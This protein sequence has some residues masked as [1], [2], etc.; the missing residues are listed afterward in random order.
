[1]S[2]LS[3]L[4]VLIV[5]ARLFGRLFA[6]Y[7]QPEVIGE[8]LA[9]V[10]L[11]PAVLDLIRP[12][13]ALAGI[14]ELAVFLVILTAGLEMKI[15]HILGAMRGRGLLL[16]AIGFVIPFL[17]GGLVGQLFGLDA[18]RTV[19][20]GLCISITALPVALKIL[21]N[22]DILDTPIGRYAVATAVV[23]DVAALLVLGVVLG[24]PSQPTFGAVATTVAVATGKLALLAGFVLALN[25][26]LEF[27]HRR[28][29]SIHVVPETLVRY[30]GAEALFGI[31]VLFVLIFGWVSEMLGFHFVIGAFFGALLLDQRHFLASRY[32]ELQK[33]L[34]SV[35]GGFL[36]PVFFAYLGLEFDIH[37][38]DSVVFAVAVLAVSVVTKMAAG[39]WGGRLV[40]MS[41]REALGLG[42]ILNG[43]GVMELVVASIAY[44]KG[45][46]NAGIFSTLVLMGIFTT[47]ITP[48]LFSRAFPPESLD[49]YRKTGTTVTR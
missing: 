18:M 9:G 36:A 31:V 1:M 23:N 48:I 15:G 27:L 19:F 12:N 25:W 5:V 3:S 45:F 16:A 26:T 14:S 28:G 13:P 41:R 29:A 30:F 21:E 8:I 40:G 11:G 39:V 32:N 4:L 34:G 6:R 24:V 7:N 17:G 46:I 22:L 35:T 10:L 38:I 47:F 44:E 37:A 49:D 20:L 33:T 2:L 42:C 43:R